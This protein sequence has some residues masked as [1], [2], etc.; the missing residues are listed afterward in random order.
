MA[1][2]LGG[3]T[4]IVFTSPAPLGTETI[5]AQCGPISPGK[6]VTLVLLLASV[7]LFAT[8]ATGLMFRIRRGA[9]LTD[10]QVVIYPSL[11]NGS[12]AASFTN[13]NFQFVDVLS[14]FGPLFYSLTLL[15]TGA[16]AGTNNASIAALLL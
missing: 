2:T 8:A 3:G 15:P 10:P 16:L 7:V 13:Y 9:N 1:Q 6:D 12:N 14:Q 4:S 5:I 11:E